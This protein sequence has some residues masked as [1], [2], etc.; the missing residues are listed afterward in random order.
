MKVRLPSVYLLR[1]VFH[2]TVRDRE[3]MI[4]AHVYPNYAA[5]S[6]SGHAP[7]LCARGKV[8]V[9]ISRHCHRRKLPDLKM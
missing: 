4:E 9:C 5:S 3:Y 2:W 1:I 8:I 6:T 7:L